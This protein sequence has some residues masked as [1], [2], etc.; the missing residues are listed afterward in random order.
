MEQ[1]RANKANRAPRREFEPAQ[2]IPTP[3]QT[4]E[5][6]GAGPYN[7]VAQLRRC[8][9]IQRGGELERACQERFRA[10][11]QLIDLL[12]ED[13][14]INLEWQ[15]NNSR[16][17]IELIY[18]SAVDNFL[19]GDVELS[20]ALLE[21]LLE[22]DPED[23][24]GATPLLA[25]NYVELEEYDAAADLEM[26]I[27]DAETLTL[28]KLWLAYRERGELPKAETALLKRSY[29]ALIEEFKLSE[30][31]ADEALLKSLNSER[32][33]AKARARDLWLKYEPLWL[34][35]PDFVKQI[36]EIE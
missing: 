17:A 26:D 10:V 11:Q 9:E 24:L 3:D 1:K 34:A 25:F 4:F 12:P 31:P 14:E 35:H 2:F 16:A 30:H 5:L 15:H 6:E 28:L 36:S 21:Q 19:V 22:L 27:S 13:E 8:E 23:H 33:S 29:S 20:V 18:L 32:P 7:Y